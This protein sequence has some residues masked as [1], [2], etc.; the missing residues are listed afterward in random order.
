MSTELAPGP[1]CTVV[2]R[3]ENGAPAIVVH[4]IGKGRVVALGTAFFR[5]VEDRQGIWWSEPG[6]TDF[7]KA[8]LDGLGQPSVNTTDNRLIWPQRYRMNNGLDDVVIVNNFAEGDKKFTLTT[9][10]DHAPSRVYRVSQNTI[11]P[12]PFTNWPNGKVVVHTA[13]GDKEVQAY[14]FR[15]HD[16]ADAAQHWWSYQQR[17]WR[18]ARTTGGLPLPPGEKALGGPDRGPVGRLEVDPGPGCREQRRGPVQRRRLE[19]RTAG[20]PD[21]CRGGLGQA[22]LLRRHFQIPA[23]WLASGTTRFEQAH[24]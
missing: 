2:A 10:L 6:E 20:C 18:P 22:D 19:D 13:I 17:M 5:N 1:D 15:T 3:F 21:L 9:T 24:V 23:D 7:W 11:T 12:V 4:K 8:L 14:I 16:A